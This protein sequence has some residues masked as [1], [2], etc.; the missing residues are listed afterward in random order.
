MTDKVQ[1]LNYSKNIG[2]FVMESHEN[3]ARSAHHGLVSLKDCS[4]KTE[5]IK[6]QVSLTVSAL[7]TCF[8][9]EGRNNCL[10]IIFP[11]WVGHAGA[12]LV[13]ALS[14]KPEG[15]GFEYFS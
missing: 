8:Y 6:L 9:K 14:Y 15:R 4:I 10:K 3:A 13:E 5:Q 1:I 12:Q 7:Y 2:T 11:M